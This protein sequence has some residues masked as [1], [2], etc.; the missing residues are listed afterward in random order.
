MKALLLP[1]GL[2]LVTLGTAAVFIGVISSGLFY[3]G[4]VLIALGLLV[5][6]AAGI[7][8]AVAPETE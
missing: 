1:A 6:L 3:P 2:A 8:R 4:V 5:V 7:V